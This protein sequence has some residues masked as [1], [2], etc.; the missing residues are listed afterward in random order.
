MSRYLSL[1]LLLLL[2]SITV[3]GQDASCPASIL[4]AMSRAN[5]ACSDLGRNILCYG[6][7]Q[8]SLESDMVL[9][10]FSKQGDKTSLEPINLIQVGGDEA[11]YSVTSLRLQ[12][13]LL[14]L[15]AGRLIS[16]VAYGDAKIINH[17][18]VLP[19][20]TLIATGLLNIRKTPEANGEVLQELPLR[21]NI[22][23][24]GKAE[25]TGWF[26]VVVP[27]TDDLG[28]VNQSLVNVE[29]DASLLQIVTAETPLLRP[30]QILDIE[31]AMDDAPCTGTPE[32]GVLIQTPNTDATPVS[33]TLNGAKMKILGTV[34]IHAQAS[35]EMRIYVLNGLAE[36]NAKD[37][38]E[39]A[40]QGAFISLNLD[41][42][43]QASS[44]PSAAQAYEMAD[45]IG[46]PVNNLGYRIN[47][48]PPTT[49]D[50][51]TQFVINSQTTPTPTPSR[52]EQIQQQCR[53]TIIRQAT[54]WGGPGTY[55][56]AI[57]TLNKDERVRPVIRVEVEGQTWY[58]LRETGW[59]NSANVSASDNCGEIPLSEVIEYP[60]YNT[61]D[62]ETC[63]T[64]NG[65]LRA[66]QEVTITFYDGGWETLREA[67]RATSVD[68]GRIT[69]DTKRFSVYAGEPIQVAPSKFYRTFTS[70]WKAEAGTYRIIAQRLSYILSC[71]VT[72]PVGNRRG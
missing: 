38:T 54:I 33:M 70:Y 50:A 66:G 35:S 58:Q 46:V 42:D 61:I 69:V 43:L 19:R 27:N 8:V 57:R 59:I 24:I 41:S 5:S 2:Y 22:I 39:L 28:W 64:R 21:S 68:P 34:L 44:A 48:A 10:N 40:P 18:D 7:G 37:S 13:N 11:Q 65:P 25:E 45:L 6:D 17:V 32:S 67:N 3:L 14:D 53:Y 62:M 47:I 29:G 26:R 20:V 16:M 36:I 31:T 49:Q 30:F 72:V 12:A 55:Y 63:N 23:A 1:S 52:I 51:I 15:E 9:T 71:D 4:L 60:S 56:E